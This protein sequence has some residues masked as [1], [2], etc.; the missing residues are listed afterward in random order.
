MKVFLSHP[1]HG[2]TEEQIMSIRDSAYY[3]L[4]SVYGNI[5]LIDN[6]FHEDAPKN[7]RCLWYLGR[8]IQQMEEADAIYFCEGWEDAR[9]CLIERQVA[10]K[11]GLRFLE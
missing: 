8:S 9:G 2:L 4:R 7:A 6:Y 11:Y 1:M 5:E 10:E 3:Y